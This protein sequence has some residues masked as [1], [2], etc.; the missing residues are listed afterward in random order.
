MDIVVKIIGIFFVAIAIVFLL[1][2]TV[3]NQLMEFFKKGIRIYF[4][5]LLRLALAVIFLLGAR[6]CRQFW[7]VFAFGILFLISGLLIFVL[8]PVKTK[9]IIQWYQRQPVM[10]HR[11]MAVMV[12]AIGIVIILSA[13]PP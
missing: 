13:V 10:L 12:L 8:G 9:S 7:I 1:K 5:G 11:V 3:M 4:V 6:E 2:P